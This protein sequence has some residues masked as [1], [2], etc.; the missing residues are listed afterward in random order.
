[1]IQHL[2]QKLIIA[3]HFSIGNRI[4][5]H[6]RKFPSFEKTAIKYLIQKKNVVHMFIIFVFILLIGQIG[7][8]QILTKK[9]PNIIL[10][11]VD[12]MGWMDT[13]VP[14]GDSVTTNNRKY[15]TPNMQKLA[16]EGVRFTN[17]YVNPVC[18]PTR[19]SILCG[20]S[21][22]RTHIT[23]WTNT[24][25]NQH[26][27]YPDSILQFPA[28]NIN[29]LS[30]K[31]HENAFQA[32]PFTEILK[33]EGYFTIH[34]GKA[35]WGSQSTPGSDPLNFGF[36]TNV[37]GTSIGHP[38][39]YYGKNNFGNKAGSITHWA[40]PGLQEFYDKD[41]FLTEALTQKAIQLMSGSIGQQKP[42]F[43][44]F[45]HY[46][47]H[48]PIQPDHRYFEKYL[49]NGL[50]ST[51]AAYATLVEGM[52]KSLGDIMHFLK[53][54]N[55]EDNTIIIF[56]SDNGGLTNSSRGGTRNTHNHPLRSGKGSVYEGGIKVPMIVKW[57]KMV[58]SGTKTSHQMMAE[59][60]FPTILEMAGAKF[61]A[62]KIDGKSLV[63]ALKSPVYKGSLRNLIFHYPHRW[64]KNEDEGIAWA[65][66][67]RRG[68]WK[69]VYLMK[70]QKLELYNIAKDPGEK[71][72]LADT[73][74]EQVA[75]LAQIMGDELRS[76]N[77]QMP[78][79]KKSGKQVAWP[80]QLEK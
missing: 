68:D 36:L 28:W 4:G 64:T 6:S 60:I 71:V 54:Q 44:N 47:I 26:T 76:K 1:M 45:G 55:Q 27:D 14:F 15:H 67:L 49:L 11:L 61:T 46:A 3:F 37:G 30:P 17:A 18:T 59:D 7:S 75:A 50:D 25:P 31:P 2:L 10:F 34:V 20:L 57:P 53:S 56:L 48:T 12:D 32:T 52:D 51:E 70:E 63:P 29:G 40:I 58:R 43:L 33:N 9:Q 39:S 77:A 38:Q 66:A 69:V 23:N 73:Y 62:A 8:S 13:S 80:D 22:V 16:D 65:S 74:P 21:A 5:D 79:W 41:V 35:H 42:F 72:N 24:P 19:T 78:L